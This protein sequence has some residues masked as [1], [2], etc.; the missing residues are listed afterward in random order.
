MF[1]MIENAV[2]YNGIHYPAG[3]VSLS[4][5]V[6][7]AMIQAGVAK[8]NS[9]LGQ[10]RPGFP[11]FHA[12]LRAGKTSRAGFIKDSTGLGAGAGGGPYFLEGAASKSFTAQMAKK[13]TQHGVYATDSYIG[14]NGMITQAPQSTSYSVYDPRFAAIN[15]AGPIL[16][17]A[18]TTLKG[19]LWTLNSADAA[20]QFT[21]EENIDSAIIYYSTDSSNANFESIF[22]GTVV[23]TVNH[24]VGTPGIGVAEISF[25]R[26]T[27]MFQI[28]R[29]L[30]PVRILG[31]EVWDSTAN[32]L[33]LLNFGQYGDRLESTNGPANNANSW[34]G[35]ALIRKMQLDLVVVG[36][37]INSANIIG[38]SSLP[39]YKLALAKVCDDIQESGADLA[40]EITHAIGG[41]AETNGVMEEFRLACMDEARVR[42]CEIIDVRGGMR[43]YQLMFARGE[44]A[45]GPHPSEKGYG[46]MSDIYYDALKLR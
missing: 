44:M 39:A 30:G 18:Q 31:F 17:G 41:A 33:R 32:P 21:P 12:K 7:Q 25:P 1:V 38:I 40:I 36:M 19:L 46:I 20:L 24:A 14:G 34:R 26:G 28:R 45:D 9:P 5:N 23:R 35:G 29:L 43:D 4:D 10:R 22:K 16:D 42:N 8:L 2:M 3:R 27:G 6:A 37:A 11:K 13:F 15:G